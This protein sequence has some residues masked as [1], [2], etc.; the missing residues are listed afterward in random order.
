MR[1]LRAGR[2][3][4]RPILKS[5]FSIRVG[6]SETRLALPQ[7]SPRPL[8]VP[9]IWRAPARTAASV[10]A[11]AFSVSLWRVDAEMA[12]GDLLRRPRRRCARSRAAACRRWCRTARPSARRP[13]TAASRHSMRIGGIGLVAV[14]EMLGVEHHL[15]PA[16][17]SRWAMLSPIMSTFSCA[18]DAERDV[19]MEIPGLADHADGR[20][21]WRRAARRGRDRWRRCGRAGA[22]C[23]R[24]RS[25]RASRLG[26]SAK[27][28]SSVGLAPGQPPST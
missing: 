1:E 19:D 6:I 5:V 20:A 17:S 25:L 3:R 13:H 26:G 24:R 16:A 10:L 7:R 15:A 8:S 27:K 4:S 2:P 12:A 14:E 28:A 23:R 21:P 22:S 11:T 9:W 18:V